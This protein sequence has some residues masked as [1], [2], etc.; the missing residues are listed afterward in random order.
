ME[1]EDCRRKKA[2]QGSHECEV[3]NADSEAAESAYNWENC[4]KNPGHANFIPVHEL[5]L[6]YLPEWCRYQSVLKNV[7]TIA[8]LTVR[9]RVF[10]TSYERPDGYSFSQHRGSDVLHT[11]SAWIG[12]IQHFTGTCQCPECANSSSPFKNYYII[13]IHTACHV[14]YNTE[15]AKSTKVDVF[16]DDEA[17]MAE[18]RTKTLTGLSVICKEE[19]RDICIFGCATHDKTLV[20]YLRG[21]TRKIEHAYPYDRLWKVWFRRKWQRLCVVVS[22]PHGQPKQVTIGEARKLLL[23]LE[24]NFTYTA[25][26]CPGSSG[27]PVI[28]LVFR[29]KGKYWNSGPRCDLTFLAPHSQWLAEADMQLNQ[30]GC[31]SELASWDFPS[32]PLN[33]G[34]LMIHKKDTF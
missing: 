13:H 5:K 19:L 24:E 3:L 22:H 20:K 32:K 23:V 2:D 10:Y 27:A 30:S 31:G 28:V 8:A 25:E 16:Y 14:V 18:S 17:A 9:L 26:T 34:L 11:G 33:K 7:R 12:I 21:E 29:E 1:L 15:E 6:D 4:T